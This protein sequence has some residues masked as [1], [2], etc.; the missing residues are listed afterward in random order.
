MGWFWHAVLDS[1]T[2]V[3]SCALQRRER[4]DGIIV[5][6]K[7][8]HVS[9]APPSVRIREVSPH[10]LA[11]HKMETLEL[12]RFRALDRHWSNLRYW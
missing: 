11:R 5:D 8:D 7:M 6:F 9:N 1:P 4:E 10:V 2:S 3:V 12:Y